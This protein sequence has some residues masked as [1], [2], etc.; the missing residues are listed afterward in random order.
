MDVSGWQTSVGLMQYAGAL[1]ANDVDFEVLEYLT[2]D[3]LKEIGVG[4][5]GHRRKLLEAIAALPSVATQ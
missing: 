1:R 5:V 2:A 3:D 4:P